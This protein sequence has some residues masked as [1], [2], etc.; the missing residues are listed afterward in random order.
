MATSSPVAAAP[1]T[2]PP[3]Q[4][5]FS[6]PTRE[7]MSGLSSED[8]FNVNANLDGNATMASNNTQ[9]QACEETVSPGP[10][11]QDTRATMRGE[12]EDLEEDFLHS[13]RPKYP[14]MKPFD[15]SDHEWR[16]MFLCARHRTPENVQI[17]REFGKPTCGSFYDI[18]VRN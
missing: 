7:N 1:T 8:S 14:M 9:S 10:E 6:E 16:K 5:A 2:S 4:F 12:S 18:N 15:H 17:V 3:P 13:D 11:E